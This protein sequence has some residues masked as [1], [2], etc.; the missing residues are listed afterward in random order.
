MDSILNSKN[1][2][3]KHNLSEH[4]TCTAHTLNLI[5]TVNSSKISRLFYNKISIAIFKKLK[6]FWNLLSRSS[7]VASD[8][9][10]DACNCKFPITTLT[11]RNSIY[12]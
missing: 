5:T 8:K 3:N 9:V 2:N 1:Y 11:R 6:S 7:T 4:M 12:F 10:E